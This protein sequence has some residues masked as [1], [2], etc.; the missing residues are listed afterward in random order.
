MT[1]LVS[2]CVGRYS[3]VWTS[4]KRLY[5]SLGVI[6]SIMAIA[7]R[8]IQVARKPTIDV[9]VSDAVK[10]RYEDLLT[11]E[12]LLLDEKEVNACAKTTTAYTGLTVNTGCNAHAGKDEEEVL[13]EKA[14]KRSFAQFFLERE[15]LSNSAYRDVTWTNDMQ[16]VNMTLL[17]HEVIPREVHAHADQLF[18]VVNGSM[19]VELLADNTMRVE[20]V[21]DAGEAFVVSSGTEHQVTAGA[22]GA[23]FMTVYSRKVHANHTHQVKKPTEEAEAK[24]ERDALLEAAGVDVV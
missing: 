6:E 20:H 10:H 14:F 12:S 23:K 13:S 11:S 19:T 18:V 5:E 9:A 17:S 16:I 2:P 7:S 3:E 22:D 15:V 1:S 4:M 8:E 21:I 24:E